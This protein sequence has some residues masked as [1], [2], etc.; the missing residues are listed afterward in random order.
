[1]PVSQPGGRTRE[2]TL[3]SPD[4]GIG[5]SGQ[6]SAGELTVVGWIQEPLS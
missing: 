6:I 2:L 5:Q 3:A 1:M 4:G